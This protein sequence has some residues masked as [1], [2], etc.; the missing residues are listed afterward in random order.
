MPNNQI[1]AEAII[2]SSYCD[3]IL[4][5]LEVTKELSVNKI[6]T[7]SYIIKKNRFMEE[8][9]YKGNNTT[10]VLLKFIS[11]MAGAFEDYCNDS[12]YILKAIHVLVKSENLYIKEGQ[13]KFISV[14]EKP[15]YKESKFVHKVLE[16]SKKITDRQ[17][18]KEVIHHV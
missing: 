15:L 18:L 6:M 12:E 13:V 16:E 14:K 7:L 5:I 11:G 2:L 1:L 10:D 3:I 4:R 9:I 17:F 8:E